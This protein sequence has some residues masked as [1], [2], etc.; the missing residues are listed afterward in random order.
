MN[1]KPLI[2]LALLLPVT[3]LA[4]DGQFPSRRAGL[5]EGAVKMGETSIQSKYCVDPTTDRKM[6]EFGTEKLKE[7]GGKVTVEVDGKIVH[8]T[9]KVTIAGHTMTSQEML[10]MVGD[11]QLTGVGHTVFDPPFPEMSA[12]FPTD[13]TSEHH[14]SGPCPADMKPGDIVTNGRKHNIND[15][16]GK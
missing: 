7:M 10:T 15:A 11:T 2:V 13:T 8:V 12:A 3:A 9:S 1:C 14:W 4:E 16:S 6:M 5:W